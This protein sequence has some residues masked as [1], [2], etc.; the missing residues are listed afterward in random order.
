MA[1]RIAASICRAVLSVNGAGF[2]VMVDKVNLG[3]LLVL[4][5]D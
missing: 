5:G 3:R 1:L 4:S 2:A